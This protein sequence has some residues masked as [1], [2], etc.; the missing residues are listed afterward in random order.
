[1]TLAGKFSRDGW[2][3]FATPISRMIANGL[4]SDLSVLYLVEAGLKEWEV[5]L[6]LSLKLA[7]QESRLPRSDS[8][9]GRLETGETALASGSWVAEMS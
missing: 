8:E 1:M 5:G 7:E 9:I 3:L 6:L 4:L 2:L